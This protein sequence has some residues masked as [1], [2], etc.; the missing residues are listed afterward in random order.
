LEPT[1]V[2]E[3]VFKAY[4][5]LV[6]P[7]KLHRLD[8][9][10]AGQPLGRMATSGLDLHHASALFSWKSLDHYPTPAPLVAGVK[11]ES[12][13]QMLMRHLSLPRLVPAW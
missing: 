5:A 2:L 1:T 7:L 10:P 11:I 6:L 4:R 3:T 9:S 8:R 12:T 13:M